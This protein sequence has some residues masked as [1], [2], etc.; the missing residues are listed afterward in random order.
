LI[1]NTPVSVYGKGRM[2]QSWV[3]KNLNFLLEIQDF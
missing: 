1:K 3:N 2:V